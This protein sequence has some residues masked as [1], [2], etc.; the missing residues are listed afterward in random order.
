[1]ESMVNV[2]LVY[3]IESENLIKNN[4]SGFRKGRSTL[5]HLVRLETEIKKAQARKQ[6]LLAIFLDIEKAF[7]LVWRFGLLHKLKKYGINGRIFNFIQD[8]L[9]DRK[10]QVKVNEEKSELFD[11]P[12]GIPQGSVISPTLLTS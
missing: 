8:F 4:Q 1:M 10:I 11:L 9:Q 3:L 7:D 12:N 2:R 5:D 6:F